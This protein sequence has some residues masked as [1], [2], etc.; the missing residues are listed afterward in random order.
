[1]STHT[2]QSESIPLPD[3]TAWHKNRAIVYAIWFAAL[4]VVGNVVALSFESRQ[5]F[6]LEKARLQQQ[7]ILNATRSNN[8]DV[9]KDNLRFLIGTGLLHDSKMVDAQRIK[10]YVE[11]RNPMLIG[12]DHTCALLQ[13][14]RMACWRPDGTRFYL[15]TSDLSP[16]RD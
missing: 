12:A 3:S 1:M 13:D 7:L 5:N 4:G 11:S 10:E 9:V 8:V 15:D 6:E 14:G 16:L 2:D